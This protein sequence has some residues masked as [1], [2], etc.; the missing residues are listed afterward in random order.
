MATHITITT[1]RATWPD[2]VAL[3]AAIK[4][5]TDATAVL[6]C[7][8]GTTAIGKKATDWTPQQIAAAQ[9]ILD[10]AAAVTPQVLAQREVDR[11]PLAYKALVLALIDQINV[12]RAALVPPKVAIT[13]AQAIAAIRDKAGTL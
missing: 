6:T 4:A 8:D 1:T 5:A 13:P 10:T 9:T 7:L 3:S 2:N 12:I 11:F